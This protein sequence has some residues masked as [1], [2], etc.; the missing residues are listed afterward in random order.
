MRGRSHSRRRQRWTLA[1]ILALVGVVLL[2]AAAPAIARPAHFSP[3]AGDGL[4]AAGMIAVL[5]VAVLAA[6]VLV[7]VAVITG[8]RENP[9]ARVRTAATPQRTAPATTDRHRIAA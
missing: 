7:L 8:L 2:A 1:T 5:C 6:V 3:P 9:G 4:S